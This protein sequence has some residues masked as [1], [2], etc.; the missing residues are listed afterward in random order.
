MTMESED[1]RSPCAHAMVRWGRRLRDGAAAVVSAPLRSSARSYGTRRLMQRHFAHIA[2]IHTGERLG[3]EGAACLSPL[4]SQWGGWALQRAPLP[5]PHAHAGPSRSIPTTGSRSP[6]RPSPP[7]LDAA[8]P[9]VPLLRL[10]SA[11]VKAEP[12]VRCCGRASCPGPWDGLAV[13][14]DRVAQRF[15]LRLTKQGAQA[16]SGS[17]RR[18]GGIAL[19][20]WCTGRMRTYCMC[21]PRTSRAQGD[22]QAPASVPHQNRAWEDADPQQ[23]SHPGGQ[24][25]P[26]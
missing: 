25:G 17:G 3:G 13:R 11:A 14:G 21:S 4:A 23:I 18:G 8:L 15:P 10:H 20:F 7:S 16:W 12:P 6:P 24:R 5:A 2:R 22:S 9:A 19:Q 1:V 26:A